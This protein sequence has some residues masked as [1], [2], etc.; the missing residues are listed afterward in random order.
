MYFSKNLKQ[1]QNLQ[2]TY[3][4][5]YRCI[6]VIDSV[7]KRNPHI[8]L[9]ESMIG[10]LHGHNLPN[11]YK[12]EEKVSISTIKQVLPILKRKHEKKKTQKA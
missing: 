4:Q 12:Q 7:L 10:A 9:W 1:S 6:F 11:N 2:T 5:I 3:V 8:L